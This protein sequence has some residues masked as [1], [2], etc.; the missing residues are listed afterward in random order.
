M[1]GYLQ[2]LTSQMIVFSTVIA[3]GL[4]AQRAKLLTD[5]NIDS[6]STIM[7]KVIY[8]IM[9]LT[10]IPS[11]GTRHDILSMFPFF[12]CTILEMVTLIILAFLVACLLHLREP[13]KSV[14]TCSAGYGNTAFVGYYILLA[15]FPEEAPLAI[16]VYAIVDSFMVWG[17]APMIVSRH[18]TGQG[19]KGMDFSRLISPVTIAVFVGF[20]FL[21]L[22]F[23]PTGTLVWDTMVNIGGMS[24][25]LALLYIGADIGRKGIKK[26][27]GRPI[28]FLVAIVRL[29]MAPVVIYLL[30]RFIGVLSE[31]HVMM[32]TIQSMTP[33]MVAITML[34]RLYHS[35]DE[36]ASG[37]VIL[38]S[39]LCIITIPFMMW[40][41]SLL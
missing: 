1:T 5:E 23:H 2:A 38:T 34:S 13:T 18:A 31:A 12:L 32:L 15:V 27:F 7:V 41:I 6:I 20:L 4:F 39:I 35:D 26:L 17:V 24:K 14:F 16:A 36:L 30:L 21:M 3:I 37:S 9:L 40:V 28:V 19:V 10:V 11:G 22:E 25:Y 33:T 8:P 29:L